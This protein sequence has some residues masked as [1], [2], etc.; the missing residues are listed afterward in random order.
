MLKSKHYLWKYYGRS[1]CALHHSALYFARLF[2]NLIRMYKDNTTEFFV[3][4]YFTIVGSQETYSCQDL[5]KC[6]GTHG[7]MR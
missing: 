7:V 6:T 5:S 1:Q 2:I 4:N 3:S